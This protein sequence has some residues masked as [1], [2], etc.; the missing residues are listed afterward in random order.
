MLAPSHSARPAQRQAPERR[1]RDDHVRRRHAGRRENH[2]RDRARRRRRHARLS[3]GADRP[4]VTAADGELPRRSSRCVASRSERC[5]SSAPRD[6]RVAGLVVASR[7]V[8]L[9]FVVRRA[10]ASRALSYAS[11]PF[12]AQ[13]ARPFRSR[14]DSLPTPCWPRLPGLLGRAGCAAPSRPSARTACPRPA[15]EHGAGQQPH[16][17][18]AA[19]AAFV[20]EAIV[21][22]CHDAPPCDSRLACDRHVRSSVAVAAHAARCRIVSIA[23]RSAADEAD[24]AAGLRA[25][26][27][28]APDRP[29]RPRGPSSCESRDRP[30]PSRPS[31]SSLTPLTSSRIALTR[32][33]AG[34]IVPLLRARSTSVHHAPVHHE[35][36]DADADEQQRLEHADR[37]HDAEEEVGR[38]Q[39]AL[40]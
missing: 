24:D 20:V 16:H 14:G 36:G 9:R 13:L 35:A 34:A 17:E 21:S 4:D 2:V 22:V 38:A 3:S 31:P 40:P 12:S 6:D 30:A 27:R 7:H 28:C 23:T 39:T 10:T 18:A 25:H 37:G 32:A 11:R 29:C 26:V 1:R 8:A 5:A 19:A 33:M 15:P